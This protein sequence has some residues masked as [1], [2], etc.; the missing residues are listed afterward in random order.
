LVTFVAATVGLGAVLLTRGGKIRPLESYH[1]FEEDY[2][3]DLDS[4]E[5]T[6]EPYQSDE[7]E[8][9]QGMEEEKPKGDPSGNSDEPE[10]PVDEDAD[11]GSEEGGGDHG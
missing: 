3:A 9:A 6:S 2:W 1:D 10:D 11:G 5:T 4:Q 8:E 7:A